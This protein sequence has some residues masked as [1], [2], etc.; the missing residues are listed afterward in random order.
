MGDALTCG[1][2]D[3]NTSRLIIA[4]LPA[5]SLSLMKDFSEHDTQD[6][7]TIA[8]WHVTDELNIEFYKED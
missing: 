2:F 1:N 3:K 7:K 4:L 8:F 6:K 5:V